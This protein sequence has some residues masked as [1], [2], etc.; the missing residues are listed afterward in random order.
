MA[1]LACRLLPTPPVIE[2]FPF[3]VSRFV[4]LFHVRSASPPNALL[5][6]NCT[7]VLE[8]PGVPPLAVAVSTPP[9]NVSPLYV[10][11]DQVSAADR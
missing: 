7:W 6:L 11:S 5:S 3:T 2:I 4:V 9:E 10:T 8:P 1:A